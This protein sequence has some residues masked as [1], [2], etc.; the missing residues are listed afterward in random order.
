MIEPKKLTKKEKDRNKKLMEE[1]IRYLCKHDLFY[2]VFL[3]TNGR[4]YSSEENPNAIECIAYGYKYYDY[5]EW[6]VIKQ[7]EY[8]NP[9]TITMTFE[10]PLYDA[11]NG[12]VSHPHA[13]EDIQKIADKYGLYPEQ[14]YA[15]SLA[16]Y[17]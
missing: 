2:D 14:G 11:Y 13:E 8:N 5:G 7:I 15:W 3:Y 12:Y 9:N 1:I 16:F 17:E 6:D 10:G 4:K